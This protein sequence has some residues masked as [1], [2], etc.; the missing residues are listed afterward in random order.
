MNL[1]RNCL[2]KVQLNASRSLKIYTKTGDKG[3]TSLFTFSGQPLP[4]RPKNDQIFKAIGDIDELNAHIGSV[5]AFCRHD[6]MLDELEEYFRFIQC[7]LIEAGSSISFQ[8]SKEDIQSEKNLPKFAQFNPNEK[9]CKV[10]EI[11]GWIDHLEEHLVEL[12]S[13]IL[14]SGGRSAAQAHICR[15]ICRRAERAVLDLK[16]QE[17][18]RFNN[19]EEQYSSDIQQLEAVCVYLNRLSDFFFNTARFINARQG[20]EEITYSA[21]KPRKTSE[22]QENEE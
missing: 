4:R 8:L 2:K 5:A 12:N 1:T 18:S 11:E 10:K 17:Q 7:D 22:G 16:T 9:T 3:T 6:P 14:Q 13:F 19:P 20:S 21:R 15:S